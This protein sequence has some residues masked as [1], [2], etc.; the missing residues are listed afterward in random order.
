MIQP[1]KN[2]GVILEVKESDYVSGQ[3]PYEVRNESGDWTPYIPLGENQ[4]SSASDTMACVSFS[5]LNVIETTLNYLL[6][7]GLLPDETIQYLI[8]SD[9]L[10]RN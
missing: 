1:F 3:L 6:A 9:Q 5:A 8:D 2:Y 4:Y 7:K 10:E